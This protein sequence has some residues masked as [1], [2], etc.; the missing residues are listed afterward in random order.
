[1]RSPFDLA[2]TVLRKH[3]CCRGI[4]FTAY[5]A[6]L[7]LI[8]HSGGCFVDDSV[9]E[10]SW[11]GM[12]QFADSTCMCY[13]R[14]SNIVAS[15]AVPYSYG[16][17]SRGSPVTAFGNRF[18]GFAGAAISAGGGPVEA[19]TN[20]IES[21]AIGVEDAGGLSKILD[22]VFVGRSANVT[23]GTP[24]ISMQP[25]GL[26]AGSYIIANNL[27]E[28]CMPPCQDT[29]TSPGPLIQLAHNASGVI[30]GNAFRKVNISDNL[31]HIIEVEAGPGAGAAAT[32][33]NG[34][35]FRAG[36][37]GSLANGRAISPR[38]KGTASNNLGVAPSAEL[39]KTDDER[40]GPARP[41]SIGVA[42]PYI[43]I[44]PGTEFEAF[45][46]SGAPGYLSHF[47]ITCG[48]QFDKDTLVR[49]YVDG[50]QSP[51]IAL[52]P[53]EA[54]GVFFLNGTSSGGEPW[55]TSLFGK[56]GQNGGVHWSWKVPFQHSVR[57]TIERSLR[58]AADANAATDSRYLIIRGIRDATQ[59]AVGDAMISMEQRPRL[60]V[61]RT[62]TTLQAYE[63][64]HNANQSTDL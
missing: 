14:N 24:L 12:V 58:L 51:S 31:S 43:D 25:S 18:Q 64:V 33:I 44:H 48:L 59:F 47:W 52:H 23:P 46:F 22:N 63:C 9:C 40:S 10:Y 55:Q 42:Y 20:Q 15:S 16:I 54:I 5:E 17:L 45:N 49:Y 38:F 27:I 4:W 28:D 60:R 30:S 36:A 26:G 2:T 39:A 50:E 11:G 62:D 37:G 57:V 32:M 35:A 19:T 29:D 7:Y 53:L 41:R 21:C 13:V 61:Q 34:N 1:M 56:T 6:G 8:Q 3:H